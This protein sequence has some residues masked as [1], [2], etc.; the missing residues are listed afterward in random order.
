MAQDMDPLS[1]TG[2]CSHRA[3]A[4]VTEGSHLDPAP[5]PHSLGSAWASLALL[6]RTFPPRGWQKCL[7]TLLCSPQDC[8]GIWILPEPLL[9]AETSVS[10][11]SKQLRHTQES[12]A[13]LC[14][15]LLP[16]CPSQLLAKSYCLVSEPRPSRG[17]RK[18]DM[19][20]S[21]MRLSAP[22]G[23]M[24]PRF[25]N[26]ASLPLPASSVICSLNRDAAGVAEAPSNVLPATPFH[27]CVSVSSSNP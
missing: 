10:L 5:S 19:A 15:S 18:G 9:R 21:W 2:T 26:Q 7:Y 22:P 17:W 23:S 20:A 11:M 16:E 14:P 6:R 8:T 12:V 24:S 13:S 4:S 3:P 1:H 27:I 25:F